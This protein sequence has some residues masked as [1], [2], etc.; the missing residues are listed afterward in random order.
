VL[1]KTVI[2]SRLTKL[3]E[4]FARLKRFQNIE[5]KEY[6]SDNDLQAILERNL[7][8]AI[9][10]CIDI[11]NYIIARRKLAFPDEQENIFI[12]LGSE[13]IIP[14]KL[15]ARIKGMV[16]FRNI[17]VHDYTEIN[18]EKVYQIFKRGLK[19]FD[20]FARAVVKFIEDDRTP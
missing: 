4:Y 10:V 15:A 11:A 3:D 19:D 12:L 9:Q 16:N 6:L 8:L 2:M 14:Q 17:L 1:D 7:Q 5:L 20:E 18:P 13:G